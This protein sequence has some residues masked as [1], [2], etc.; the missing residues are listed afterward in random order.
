MEETD[1]EE[2]LVLNAGTD[3]TVVSAHD[4]ASYDHENGILVERIISPSDFTAV[5][6]YEEYIEDGWEVSEVSHYGLFDSRNSK[7][8]WGLFF[9]DEPITISYKLLP[10][11]DVFLGIEPSGMASFDGTKNVL[12]NQ[13]TIEPVKGTPGTVWA[14]FRKE[15]IHGETIPVNLYITPSDYESVYAIEQYI[16][17]GWTVKDISHDGI[18]DTKN[19]KLNGA[20]LR[21]RKH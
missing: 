9:G 13:N 5:Y 1:G 4:Y 15:F 6:A 21:A 14:D 10:K 7:V 3:N 8:K 19:S 12:I 2:E 20:Y 18:L 11:T 16:P 17:N